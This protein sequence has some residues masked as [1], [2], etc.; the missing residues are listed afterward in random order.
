VV[1]R[2]IAKLD[3]PV[4]GESG[5]LY[6]A[7]IH[8]E[9]CRNYD[10]RASMTLSQ[11]STVLYYVWGVHGYLPIGET[12]TALR[13]TSPSGGSLHPIEAYPLVSGVVGLQPGLYHYNVEHH[14]LDLLS[15]LSP[16]AC[17]RLAEQVLAGQSYF[18][19]AHV[20]F[21]TTA[22]FSRNYWKY[23]HQARAYGVILMDAG[24]LSQ[25]LYLVSAAIGLGAY[26]TAAINGANI[27]DVLGVD[28]ISEGAIAAC[29]CGVPGAP[30]DLG[31]RRQALQPSF[32]PYRPRV[33]VIGSD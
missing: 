17:R 7:L 11:L 3:L 8:R 24:H 29:G 25:T 4:P 9:T 12:I 1:D 22:R 27:D 28:G 33:T 6:D 19:G 20:T 26:V 31:A 5:G 16:E 23:R 10:R 14:R 32:R 15:S 13:K 30:I 2:A 18:A 21:L